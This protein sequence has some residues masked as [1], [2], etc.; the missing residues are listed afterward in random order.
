MTTT[1]TRIGNSRGVRIPKPLIEQY[2]LDGELELEA[3]ADGILIHRAR[4]PRDGWEEAFA[5][6]AKVGAAKL[7]AEDRAWLNAPLADDGD[8]P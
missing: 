7:G 3:T 6:A 2:G 1:L 5:K 4:R 8:A